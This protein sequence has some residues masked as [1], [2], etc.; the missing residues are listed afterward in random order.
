MILKWIYNPQTK[1]LIKSTGAVV[2][3]V[4]LVIIL[5][6]IILKTFSP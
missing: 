1:Q 3:I 4:V 2:F 5:T 6:G